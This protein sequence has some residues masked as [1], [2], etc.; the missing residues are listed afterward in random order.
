MKIID[1]PETVKVGKVE[2]PLA[3][4]LP[5][6]VTFKEF[7]RLHVD[8]YTQVKTPKQ[9]RQVAKVYDA[10]ENAKADEKGHETIVLE[11]ADYEILKAAVDESKYMPGLARQLLAFNEA[12]ENPQTV[13]KK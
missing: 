10:I 12:V 3:D 6:E 2:S 1:V 13:K 8:N 11:D 5:A 4:Q 9:I 7:L